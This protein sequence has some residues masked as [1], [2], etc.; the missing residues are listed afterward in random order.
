MSA[1]P[2]GMAV[3]MAVMAANLGAGA[4][5]KVEASLEVQA[6]AMRVEDLLE[7]IPETLLVV[8][9][10]P[11]ARQYRVTKL[12]PLQVLGPHPRKRMT[13][14]FCDIRNLRQGDI[15]PVHL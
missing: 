15:A 12:S 14:C 3:V 5:V 9:L 6:A 8:I 13:F 1:S 2:E 7:A 10:S 11:M 4:A